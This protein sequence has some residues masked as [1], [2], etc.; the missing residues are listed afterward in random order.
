M[1][2]STPQCFVSLTAAPYKSK[3]KSSDASKLAQPNDFRVLSW[4]IKES[5]TSSH[6]KLDSAVLRLATAAP[7]KSKSKSSDASKLAQPLCF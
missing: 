5:K 4:E 3:S 1:L 2:S 7:Y 6:A